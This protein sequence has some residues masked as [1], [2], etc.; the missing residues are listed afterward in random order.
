MTRPREILSRAL[1]QWHRPTT[2]APRRHDLGELRNKVKRSSAAVAR[3]PAQMYPTS[4][5]AGKDRY[6]ARDM[7]YVIS[8]L[9]VSRRQYLPPNCGNGTRLSFRPCNALDPRYMNPR[10]SRQGEDRRGREVSRWPRLDARSAVFYF[11]LFC[12]IF[13]MLFSLS[14]SLFFFFF[15]RTGNWQRRF[16]RVRPLLR[17]TQLSL[18]LFP[19]GDEFFTA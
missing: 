3:F 14:L 11:I 15:T 12:F 13:F 5:S 18:C 9:A 7:T 4:E 10:S 17:L 1:L 16:Y 6:R 19:H 8:A 2:G